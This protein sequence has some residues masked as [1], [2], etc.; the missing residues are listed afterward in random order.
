MTKK[1]KF[2]INTVF[3][4]VEINSPIVI[5]HVPKHSTRCYNLTYY[6]VSYGGL[7][8]FK[9]NEK[10]LQTLLDKKSYVVI[11]DPDNGVPQSQ[12]E[13]ADSERIWEEIA[14]SGLGPRGTG[15]AATIKLSLNADK[16]VKWNVDVDRYH[17]V[18]IKKD[19]LASSSD[20]DFYDIE[21]EYFSEKGQ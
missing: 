18:S 5:T 17:D 8:E 10:E 3:L 20:E 21:I 12:I 2:N 4:N 16:Q 19:H 1:T 13:D 11:W 6:D 14:E 15:R 7:I 9:M